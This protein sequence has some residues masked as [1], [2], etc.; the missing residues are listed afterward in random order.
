MLFLFIVIIVVL[1]AIAIYLAADANI[2]SDRLREQLEDAHD[3]IESWEEECERLE[4][5]N[6]VL[7]GEIARLE[8][9]Y[10]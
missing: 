1:C 7:E 6:H 9:A 2:E 4:R 10:A 3:A 5:R 8:Q